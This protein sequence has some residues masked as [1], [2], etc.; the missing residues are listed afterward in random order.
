M[1]D[2]QISSDMITE[3]EPTLTWNR[4]IKEPV[5]AD[6]KRNI[7]GQPGVERPEAERIRV[8]I[9]WPT[10]EESNR[11]SESGSSAAIAIAYAKK[12]ISKI[13]NPEVAGITARNGDEL[14]TLRS[15][16][17]RKAWQLAM[18]VGS[19]IFAQSFLTESE[20]KN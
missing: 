5:T 7:A 8:E 16:G 11:L 10:I 17:N 18:N 20:E 15:K 9:E 4:W 19:Y 3:Y 12:C 2:K 1:T 14:L 6:P 13:T